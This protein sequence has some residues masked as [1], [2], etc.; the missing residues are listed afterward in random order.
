MEERGFTLHVRSPDEE[1]LEMMTDGRKTRRWV[2][3]TCFSW[4]AIPQVARAIRANE[5]CVAWV[6]LE[7]AFIVWSQVGSIYA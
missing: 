3:E 5:S 6:G 4:F 2:V 7:S 1:K